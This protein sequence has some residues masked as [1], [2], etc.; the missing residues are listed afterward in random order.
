VTI[1]YVPMNN[2]K[3]TFEAVEGGS[4]TIDRTTVSTVWHDPD[5]PDR[6][7]VSYGGR[8]RL[9]RARPDDVIAWVRS[10]PTN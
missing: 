8:V 6:T 7:E 10:T 9:I 2:D 3:R 5:W 4:V 1:W